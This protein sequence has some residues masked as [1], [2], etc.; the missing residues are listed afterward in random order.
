LADNIKGK[1]MLAEKVKV[2]FFDDIKCAP[3]SKI[4]EL[5]INLCTMESLDLILQSIRTQ[6][7]NNLGDYCHF[8]I[9]LFSEDLG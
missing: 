9:N 5:T 2:E 7:N 1:Q 6:Q 3:K 4:G 8:K